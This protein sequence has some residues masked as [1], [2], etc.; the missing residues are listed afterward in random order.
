MAGASQRSLRFVVDADDADAAERAAA[1]SF[2]AGASGLEE[3]DGAREGSVTLWVYAAAAD[4]ADV[5]RALSAVP[6]A[7]LRGD[8]E[9]VEDSDWS[10][11]WR[12]GLE[13]LVI[14]PELVV[15][16][17]CVVAS[18]G[19]GQAEV[20]IDPGQA[21]GTGGHESTRLAL[22]L[23]AALPRSIRSGARVLDVGTGSGVLALAA[24]RLG[25]RRALGVDLDAVAVA[26]ARE[27]AARNGLSEDLELVAGS[28]GALSTAAFDLVLANLLKREL[29]PLAEEIVRLLRP[30][31]TLI[32][33][34][35]LTAEHAEVM[36]A[37][38]ALGL[39]EVERAE[40]RDASGT[41]W[42]GLRLLAGWV[43]PTTRGCQ[44][45]TS[46]AT[47]SEV[48]VRTRAAEVS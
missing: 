10:A 26:V 3:R 47:A 16:P 40:R 34:G 33:S 43:D 25:A 11:A 39:R 30:G 22:D 9:L 36:A 42:L 45:G 27:N 41:R 21:F 46:R 6:G 20:V 13:A 18:L 15:R 31:A 14:S 1:E 2:S 19:P 17:S 5:A 23:L 29:L 37:L 38:S 12:E 35:I 24:L 48:G 32:V 28:L 7:R 44:S 8:P 4:V